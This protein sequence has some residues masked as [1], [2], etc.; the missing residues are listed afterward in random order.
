V[1]CRLPAVSLAALGLLACTGPDDDGQGGKPPGPTETSSA[2]TAT[3]PTSDTGPTTSLPP[4]C[5]DSLA[6]WDSVGQPL[7]LTW[8]TPCHSEGVPEELRQDAPLGID[9]DTYEQTVAWAARIQV[10]AVYTVDMPPSGGVPADE[11]ALLD[12][13]IRCGTPGEEG[14]QPVDPCLSAVEQPGDATASSLAC[15]P[16]GVRIDGS[17][18]LDADADLSCIC[19]VSGDVEATGAVEVD[20][21]QLHTIGGDLTLGG[22]ALER[23][24]APALLQVQAISI[25]DAPALAELDL[26]DVRH[27]DSLVASGLDTLPGLTFDELFAVD[28]DVS[29][30]DLPAATHV[31]L[32]RLDTIGGDY[33]L[34]DL[35]STTMLVSSHSI[36]EVGG[37]LVLDDL[38][39][40]PHV[41]DFSEVTTIGG[42]VIVRSTGAESLGGFQ[43]L[44]TIGGDLVVEDN[45]SLRVARGF[46][47]ITEVGGSLRWQRND[48]LLQWEAM[49]FLTSVGGDFMVHS[50]PELREIPR[51]QSL[52]TISGDFVFTD[53]P[54]IANAS[55]EQLA[56]GID[57]GGDVTIGA[58]GQ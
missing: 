9:F 53:N 37:D 26:S 15:G 22:P 23:F 3:S 2:D 40:L 42:D 1:R 19:E 20:L 21:P 12:E 35:P 30:T 47:D 24:T 51:F 57:I 17:L 25:T 49:A 39:V 36:M 31:T 54:G 18:Q 13:W 10:R 48:V 28:G 45:P 46:P 43:R 7:M 55:A 34:R 32:A 52:A 33:V 50:H 8:C 14:P 5:A 38:P 27:A 29:V 11:L 6:T 58:S 44:L 56:Q 16:E 41:D 4:E